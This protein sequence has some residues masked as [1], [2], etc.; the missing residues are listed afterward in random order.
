MTSFVD[1]PL[2]SLGAWYPG[3]AWS[4]SCKHLLK[5]E[6]AG[7]SVAVLMVRFCELN[8][9]SIGLTRVNEQLFPAGPIQVLDGPC[10]ISLAKEVRVF[11]N[12]LH[13]EH[14]MVQ[15]ATPAKEAV[16]EGGSL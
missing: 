7:L 5:R 3:S 2:R 4:V 16:Q 15:S 14:D 12:V 9:D 11:G 10:V 13:A 1:L 8:E 6:V